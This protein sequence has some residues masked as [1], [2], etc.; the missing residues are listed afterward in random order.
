MR[1]RVGTFYHIANFWLQEVFKVVYVSFL[2][3]R[4]THADIDQSFSSKSGK[5]RR[6]DAIIM[7]DI[8]VLLMGCYEGRF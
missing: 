4:H 8:L 7:E 5:L 1:T 3:V 6:E 2:P